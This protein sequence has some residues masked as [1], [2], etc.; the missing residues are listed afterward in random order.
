MGV[1]RSDLASLG[2]GRPR[3]HRWS[4]LD[5]A[6]NLARWLDVAAATGMPFDPRLWLSNPI[7]STYPACQAVVAAREQGPEPGYRYLR[8]LARA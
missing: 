5:H 3:P 6:A 4:P 7:S 8:R 2:D 1:R